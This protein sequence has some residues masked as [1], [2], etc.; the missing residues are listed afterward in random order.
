MREKRSTHE[1]MR[2]LY[3]E[4][5]TW[6][7]QQILAEL[8]A[9]PVLPDEDDPL[10]NEASWSQVALFLALAGQAATRKLT[11]AIPLLLERASYG[12]RGETMRGLRHYLERIVSPNWSDLTPACMTV[13]RNGA[14]GARLWSIKEL[15]MLEDPRSLEVLLQA[16][17]DPAEK[18]REAACR[19]L[20][21]VCVNNKACRLPAL[22]AL[23]QFVMKHQDSTTG[24]EAIQEILAI[25]E[26][27]WLTEDIHHLRGY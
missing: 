26:G 10:W 25:T 5:M 24:Q 17:D 22:T 12:D 8:Q 3:S 23:Q 18:V 19:S 21:D 13:A 4:R 2:C 16:L 27:E 7:D 1:E 15:G 6:S 9:L 11:A 20:V 14:R